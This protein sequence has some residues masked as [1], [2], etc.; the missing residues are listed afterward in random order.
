M[1]LEKKSKNYTL[2]F[3]RNQ[4]K[5][6]LIL[7]SLRNY[8]SRSGIDI[9]PY[10]WVREGSNT[11]ETPKIKGNHR[12]YKFEFLKVKDLESIRSM[13]I[14][15]NVDELINDLQNGRD[16]IGLKKNQEI[17][18]LMFIEYNS[19][20]LKGRTFTLG[21]EDAYLLNMYTFNKFRG[22][23]LAPYLRHKS[24]EFLK[25]KG[26]VNIYSITDYFN[27]SSIK[28]KEK[29]KAENVF[30]YLR[31]SLLKKKQWNFILKKYR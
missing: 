29:L 28:F 5:N 11:Y 13:K 8:I 16:C 1:G 25:K 23:N 22:K 19:F 15:L 4:V 17:A 21:E 27:F 31:V 6:G 7:F 12:D 3:I 10:Y 30:L 20:E 2:S 24:Y 14:R 26:N 9:N 18:A